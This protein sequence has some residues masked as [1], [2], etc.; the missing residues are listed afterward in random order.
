MKVILIPEN[1]IEINV[2]NTLYFA[3]DQTNSVS[4]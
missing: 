4:S 2:Q 3:E 1:S